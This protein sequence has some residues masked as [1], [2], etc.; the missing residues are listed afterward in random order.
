M[1]EEFKVINGLITDI[2]NK[3]TETKNYFIAYN[4]PI[5]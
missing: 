3:K 1:K 2:I 4:L 5:C